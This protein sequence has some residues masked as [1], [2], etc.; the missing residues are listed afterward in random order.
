MTL[1]SLV[2]K[3]EISHRRIGVQIRFTDDD[4]NDYLENSKRPTTQRQTE[5][6]KAQAEERESIRKVQAAQ[7]AKR[8]SS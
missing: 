4:V 6:Q 3:G 7:R 8:K 2:S 5:R 1:R